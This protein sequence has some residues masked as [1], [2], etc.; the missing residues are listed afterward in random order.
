M[1]K[2]L[3]FVAAILNFWRP[4]EVDNGYF[5]TMYSSYANDHLYQFWCFCHEVNDRCTNWLHYV[6]RFQLLP[7]HNVYC[8]FP[9]FPCQMCTVTTISLPN[10]AKCIFPLFPF[11][12]VNFSFLL[13]PSLLI[14]MDILCTFVYFSIV[15]H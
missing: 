6:C 3:N 12:N 10:Y 8:R 2:K 13:S 7:F 9:L 14:M 11:H 15:A 4:S 1:W 5:L